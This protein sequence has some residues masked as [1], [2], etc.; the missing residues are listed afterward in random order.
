[1]NL[2]CPGNDCTLTCKGTGTCSLGGCKSGCKVA[3]KGVGTCSC[4]TGC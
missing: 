3:C 4:S 2:Q 1:V